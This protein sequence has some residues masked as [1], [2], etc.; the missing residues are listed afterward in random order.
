MAHA[1]P[2]QLSR[3]S[4]SGLKTAAPNHGCASVCL[5]G[6]EGPGDSSDSEEGGGEQKAEAE[7]GSGE[8]RNSCQNLFSAQN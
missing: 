5:I 4:W 3:G 1:H 6:L 8:R 7:R 2:M